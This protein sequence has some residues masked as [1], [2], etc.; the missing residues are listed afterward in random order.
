MYEIYVCFGSSLDNGCTYP[1]VAFVSEKA[2]DAWCELKN[3]E[4]EGAVFTGV[5]I[6]MFTKIEVYR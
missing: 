3:K 1:K 2:A 6:Y 5:I 4:Q